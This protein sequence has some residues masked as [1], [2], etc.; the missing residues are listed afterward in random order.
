MNILVVDDSLVVRRLIE[1]TLKEEFG[2]IHTA[3]CG[4]SALA[5]V[6]LHKPAIVIL[7]IMM[8]NISG[9][10]VCLKIRNNP[11][12]YGDPYIIMLTGKDDDDDVISGFEAGADD[13]LKKPF[14]PKELSLRVKASL[15]KSRVANTTLYYKNITL[16]KNSRRV[17]IDGA[18]VK[19]SSKLFN[20]LSFFIEN[21]GIS[22]SRERIYL[23]VWEEEFLKG[24]RTVDVYVRRL[25]DK[26]PQL[27]GEI[28]S[29]SGF[30]YRLG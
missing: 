13:Y 9:I 15:R 17:E 24:N 21:T 3:V 14:N 26:V 4:E 16:F 5:S 1:T 27:E 7:D 20:L 30:G 23:Q 10:D 29:Q 28:N 6:L 22:L 12:I 18:E 8:P 19:L 2:R 25:K 11:K